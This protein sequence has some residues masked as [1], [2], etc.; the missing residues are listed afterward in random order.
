MNKSPVKP[1]IPVKELPMTKEQFAIQYVLIRAAAR[2]DSL[3][4]E[5][6]ANSACDAWD[7]IQRR[8]NQ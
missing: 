1:R 2:P 8:K 4:G 3:D 7:V 5:T 6:V